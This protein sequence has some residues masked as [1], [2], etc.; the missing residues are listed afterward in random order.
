MSALWSDLRLAFTII[1]FIFLLKWSTDILDNKPLGVILAAVIAYLTFFS[2]YELLIIAVIL[3]F[4]YPVFKG[5][6]E[7]MAESDDED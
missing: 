2:H 1:A 5:F 7:A 3:F 4:G 6:A